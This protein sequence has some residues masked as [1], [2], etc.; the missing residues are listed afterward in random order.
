MKPN[1][2]WF[3]VLFGHVRA[4]KHYPAN[5]GRKIAY[6]THVCTRRGCDYEEPRA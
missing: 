4:I 2:P 1:I 5:D 6:S 3:C